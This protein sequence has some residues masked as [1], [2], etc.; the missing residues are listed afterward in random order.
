VFDLDGLLVD[1]EPLQAWAWD[2][3]LARH[4]RRMKPEVLAQMLG[5]RAVD[6]VEIVVRELALPMSGADALRERDE[7]FLAA[8]PGAVD[9]MPGALDLLAEL[10][11]RGVPTALATSGHRRYVDLSLASAG[12]HEAFDHEVTGEMVTRGKPHPDVYLEAARLLDLP[13]SACLA[14]EDA[15]NGVTSAVTAG[16]LCFAV[17]GAHGAAQDVSHAH[18]VLESLE[19]VIPALGARGIELGGRAAQG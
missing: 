5:L 2:V 8:V 4:G 19:E 18:A 6:A 10:R 1:S 12:L 3:F 17:P 15:P 16:M 13:A 14:L 9:A 11:E 7:L